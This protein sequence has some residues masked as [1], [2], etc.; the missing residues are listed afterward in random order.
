[1]KKAI[2][3]IISIILFSSANMLSA[4]AATQNTVIPTT[5]MSCKKCQKKIEGQLAKLAGVLSSEAN[6]IDETVKVQFDDEKTTLEQI[7]ATIKELGYK[8]KQK[9]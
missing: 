9:K 3:A 8:V 5:G 1:M 6:K 2:I 7:I 4:Q